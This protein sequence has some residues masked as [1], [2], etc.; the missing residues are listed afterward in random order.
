MEKYMEKYLNLN[1]KKGLVFIVIFISIRATG[2]QV[3]R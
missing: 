2:T 3:C 1:N